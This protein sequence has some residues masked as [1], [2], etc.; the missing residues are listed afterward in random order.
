M[1][2]IAVVATVVAATLGSIGA[3]SAAGVEFDV[4]RG[5]VYVGPRHHHY[6]HDWRAYD[7]A[8]GCRVVV[9]E[10]I[11]RFGERVSVRRRICD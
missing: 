2:R 3:A 7:Y 10:H 6:R 1:K 11:N 8:R 5:G 9:R 4:G